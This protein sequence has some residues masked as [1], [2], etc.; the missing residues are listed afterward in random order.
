M[1]KQVQELQAKK[2]LSTPHEVLE[3]QKKSTSEAVAKITKGEKLY[4]EAVE[5]IFCDMGR[6]F[7]G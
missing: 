7:R 5:F 4:A 3:E 2:I 1:K 6:A